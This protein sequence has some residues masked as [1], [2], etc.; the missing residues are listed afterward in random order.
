[1]VFFTYL[2]LTSV[3]QVPKRFWALFKDLEIK[4]RYV[5]QSPSHPFFMVALRKSV[6]SVTK[7][8]LGCGLGR[9]TQ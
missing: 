6:N 4:T 5:F 1:M 3:L 8:V 7:D 9:H 2:V